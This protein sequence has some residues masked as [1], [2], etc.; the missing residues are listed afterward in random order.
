MKKAVPLFLAL[1][2]LVLVIASFGPGTA[3]A[4]S[5]YTSFS[6]YSAFSPYTAFS[7]YSGFYPSFYPA[8]YPSFSPYAGFYPSFTPTPNCGNGVIDPGE[9]CDGGNLNG[10]SC[11]SQGFSGGALSCDPSCSSFNTSTCTVIPPP[12]PPP[13]PPP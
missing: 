8:F 4:S 5:G 6:P 12:P 9:V 11:S 2:L 3:K 10:Q 13:G 7:P 1:I